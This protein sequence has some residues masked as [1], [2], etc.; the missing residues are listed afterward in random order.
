MQAPE[1]SGHVQRRCYAR[2]HC[3]ATLVG[4]KLTADIGVAIWQIPE[5]K[6]PSHACIFRNTATNVTKT[7]LQAQPVRAR[8]IPQAP[9]RCQASPLGNATAEAS[10]SATG[11]GAPAGKCP[12]AG[13]AGSTKGLLKGN[14][15]VAEALE[16]PATQSFTAH[17]FDY[18]PFSGPNYQVQ[19]LLQ[20]CLEYGIMYAS[21]QHGRPA[22]GVHGACR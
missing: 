21:L 7:Y 18:T 14:G 1:A 15:A 17:K 22:C 19:G 11:Q 4:R 16:M 12:F 8:I 10:G 5:P 13:I 6:Q 2:A 3:A 20:M 9:V